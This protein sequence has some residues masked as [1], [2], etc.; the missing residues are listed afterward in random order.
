MK[1]A[2]GLGVPFE[3]LWEMIPTWTQRDVERAKELSLAN[4]PMNIYMDKIMGKSSLPAGPTSDVTKKGVP[5][6]PDQIVP[7]YGVDR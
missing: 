2:Q 1:L 3:M 5:G 4:D 7:S 6:N